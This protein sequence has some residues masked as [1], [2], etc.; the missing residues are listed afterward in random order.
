VNPGLVVPWDIASIRDSSPSPQCARTLA[1]GANHLHSSGESS[2]QGPH[3]DVFALG[4]TFVG[5][6]PIRYEQLLR[7]DKRKVGDLN[8]CYV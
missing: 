8:C 3:V 5:R 1:I 7:L 4:L 2:R 6:F